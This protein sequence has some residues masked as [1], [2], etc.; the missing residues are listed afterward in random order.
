MAIDYI[1][2]SLKKKLDVTNEYMKYIDD[3]KKLID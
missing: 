2:N 3:S 1:K